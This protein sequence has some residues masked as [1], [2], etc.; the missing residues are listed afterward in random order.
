MPPLVTWRA[1]PR[2][3]PVV[4]APPGRPA[5]PRDPRT[6]SRS[7]S[8]RAPSARPIDSRSDLA[9][10][11]DLGSR[12]SDLGPGKFL[13]RAWW[14]GPPC[15]LG[16]SRPRSSG[17]GVCTNHKVPPGHAGKPARPGGVQL[18]WWGCVPLIHLFWRHR[19][20][21]KGCCTSPRETKTGIRGSQSQSSRRL[22][23]VR[24][25]SVRRPSARDLRQT[26]G[27]NPTGPRRLSAVRPPSVRPGPP[28]DVGLHLTYL[29]RADTVGCRQK[30]EL[31]G[32]HPHHPKGRRPASGAHND[33][34]LR[35]KPPGSRL[36]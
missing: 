36:R 5:R 4:R 33:R 1:D 12:T 29:G 17:T 14:W 22:S 21:Q 13:P 16:G 30:D 31:G 24:P 8:T 27:C 23:A 35:T 10:V 7:R 15:P 2:R 11:P 28:P 25:L 20:T 18:W 32:T 34:D 6:A 26:L 3:T 9:E 19:M